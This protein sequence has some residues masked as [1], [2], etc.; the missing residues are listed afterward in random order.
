MT[1]KPIWSLTAA[2]LIVLL[3]AGSAYAQTAATPGP[4]AGAEAEA[5]TEAETTA[6]SEAEPA[7]V[8]DEDFAKSLIGKTYSG[9]FGL[10]GWTNLGGGL[11]LPPFYVHHYARDDGTVLVVTAKEGSAAGFEVADALVAGKPRKGY[12]FSTSCMK[13]EDYTLRFMGETS[14]KDA[15]EWWT[16][17]NKAWEIDIETGKISSVNARGVKCTNPNW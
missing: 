3:T 16:N 7:P 6:E 17:L 5:A 8:S 9:S 10:D 2:C 14:G 11:V 13:G 4:E 1:R 15:A 12:T